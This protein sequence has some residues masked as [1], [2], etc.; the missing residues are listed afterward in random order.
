MINYLQQAFSAF[1]NKQYLQVIEILNSNKTNSADWYML[2]TL[3]LAALN[4][5]NEAELCYNKALTLHPLNHALIDNYTNLLCKLGKYLECMNWCENSTEALKTQKAYF[6]YIES[7]IQTEHLIQAKHHLNKISYNDE[8]LTRFHWLQI[9]LYEAL[10]DLEKIELQFQQLPEA[11]FEQF[12]FKYKRACNFRNLGQFQEALA[13][14]LSL[15]K[16][17]SSAELNYVIGCTYYDLKKLDYAEIYLKQCL[18]QAPNYIPAHESLNKLYWEKSAKSSLMSSYQT[19]LKK[20]PANPVLIHSQ[21]GQLLQI[22]DLESAMKISIQAVNLFKD[23]LDLKHA[24]SIVLDKFGE[25]EQAFNILYTLVQQAPENARYAVDLSN[26]YI[27]NHEY[28]LSVKHLE[29]AIKFNPY[30]QELWA[31]LS[32]AWRL[33]NDEKYFWLTNYQQFVRVMELPP[34]KGYKSIENF[35]D[36]LKSLLLNLHT[37]DKQPLDQSV[38]S[39]S[40]TTGHLLYRSNELLNLFKKSMTSC[41]NNYLMALPKDPTHPLLVRNQHRFTTKGSWSVKLDHG[42]YHANHIHPHGWLSAPSY[43]SIPDEMN[44]SDI[45]KSGWLKLGETSLELGQREA[46]AMEVCP[47]PGQIIIFPSYI[48]HGTHKLIS[49]QPRLT[50][51]CDIMPLR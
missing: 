15:D 50:I 13:L 7:L 4:N 20:F 6:N 24:Y 27:Q 10:G 19:T 33:L 49:N 21:I 41:I 25:H 51:P 17:H 9:A 43:I 36:D 42:G 48:W 1:N 32:T 16:I 2:Y 40:Q 46:I 3:T 8:L 37:N 11:I 45:T 38:R 30:N 26:F 31:Y 14:F 29:E 18:A 39:G 44:N 34:P 12:H 23:N 22:N 47:E 5:Y 28:K 35:N